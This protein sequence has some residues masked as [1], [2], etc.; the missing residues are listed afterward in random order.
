[1]TRLQRNP[2]S[3]GERHETPFRRKHREPRLQP[4]ISIT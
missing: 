3:V 1:M 4:A 2:K